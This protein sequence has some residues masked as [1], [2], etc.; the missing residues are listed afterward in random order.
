MRK[1]QTPIDIGEIPCYVGGK[2]V[3]FVMSNQM[4]IIELL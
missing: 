4:N 2:Q 1:I 3:L